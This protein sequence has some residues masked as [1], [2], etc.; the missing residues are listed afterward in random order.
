MASTAA[1][2]LT[3]ETIPAYL[4]SRLD[5][6]KGVIDSVEGIEVSTIMG[7]NVNYA[8]FIKLGNGSTVFLKQAPEFVAIFGPDGYPLT[9]ER[10]QR[11]MDVYN[12]WKTIL[13]EELN[14]KYLPE[15]HYFDSEYRFDTFIKRRTNLRD[16][17]SL[18]A[19]VFSKNYFLSPSK[20]QRATCVSLWNSLTGT[21]YWTMF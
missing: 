18:H 9:S 7:G 12:E 11:E 6:L 19:Y 13:G 2:I 17:D 14:K 16:Y 5:K 4:S 1:E 20:C 8:F 15:I 21:I 10:M 3:V